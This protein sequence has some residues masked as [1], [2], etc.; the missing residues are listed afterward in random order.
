MTTATPEP[1][2]YVIDVPA[3]RITFTTRHLFGLSTVRLSTVRGSFKLHGGTVSPADP[4]AGSRVDAVADASSFE[5][6]NKNRDR[7]VLS[8]TLLDTDADTSPDIAF[9]STA[10]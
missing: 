10:A 3:S 1:G 5:T 2:Q 9:T 4:L 7:Q 6:G 8:R